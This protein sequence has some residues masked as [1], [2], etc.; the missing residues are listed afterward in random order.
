[1][2][3]SR[4][5]VTRTSPDEY[6]VRDGQMHL[7]NGYDYV[8]QAWVSDGK[9]SDCG[10]Q[11]CVEC[12]C[13]GRRFKG[14]EPQPGLLD[15]SKPHLTSNIS[16]RENSDHASGDVWADFASAF[17]EATQRLTVARYLDDLH[18]VDDEFV[19]ELIKFFGAVK[20]LYYMTGS[21]YAEF[22]RSTCVYCGRETQSDWEEQEHHDDAVF[23]EKNGESKT[24]HRFCRQRA[25]EDGKVTVD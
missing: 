12:K 15:G 1:M 10:H 19:D 18:E 24:A 7:V 11:P 4:T 2:K 23:F 22:T 3:E 6:E 25:V 13:Y 21:L 5:D 17:S 16:V 8:N 9:Y 20:N 14:T